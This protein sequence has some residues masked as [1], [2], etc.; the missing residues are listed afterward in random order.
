MKEEIEQAGI[1]AAPDNKEEIDRATH[2]PVVV[3]YKNCL[4][5]WKA[6]KEGL[7]TDPKER[8]VLS[9]H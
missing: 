8:D 7:R 1:V 5:V 4:P 3:E 6:V 9:V 2:D